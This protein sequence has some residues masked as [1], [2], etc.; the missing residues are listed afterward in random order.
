MI[1]HL[2]DKMVAAH[3]DRIVL[4]QGERQLSYFELHVYVEWMA[5]YFQSLGVQPGHRVAIFMPKVHEFVI[6]IL[7][8][9]RLQ[10]IAVPLTID[11]DPAKIRADLEAAKV[12]AVITLPHYRELLMEVL[13]SSPNG[14][15]PLAKLPLAIFEEDNIAT[16][17]GSALPQLHGALSKNLMANGKDKNA[18]S[19]GRPHAE[20][21]VEES[22]CAAAMFF[23]ARD[24][25]LQA[26]AL[27]SHHA[28]LDEAEKLAK[29][30]Q[31]TCDD[32]I[33]SEL[34]FAQA[35][36]LVAGFLVALITGAKMVLA[37]TD[38][39]P[40]LGKIFWQERVTVFSGALARFGQLA[41]AVRQKLSGTH[42]LRWFWCNDNS[43]SP[44][45]EEVL[46]QKFGAAIQRL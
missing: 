13:C 12:H 18:P 19:N 25:R 15:W 22:D 6:S 45:V 40:D 27:Y 10:G 38:S 17:R 36:G 30:S 42:A 14:A 16:S 46:R 39:L 29:L 26:P 33:F 23:Y 44:G 32:C 1:H 37:E 31:L 20:N 21:G 24:G 4:A 8:L 9:L 2:F 7:G 5:R 35:Q 3:S 41:E 28:L 11:L 34:S 43:L